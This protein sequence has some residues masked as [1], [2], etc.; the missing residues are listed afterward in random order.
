MMLLCSKDI[1]SSV[2]RAGRCSFVSR[3]QQRLLTISAAAFPNL[4][5]HLSPPAPAAVTDH[6]AGGPL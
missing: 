1:L 3:A 6:Q 4:L 5:L 2:V